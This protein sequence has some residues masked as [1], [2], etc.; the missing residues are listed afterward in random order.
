MKTLFILNNP[1]KLTTCLEAMAKDD[2]LLLIEDAV[3]LTRKNIE[4]KEISLQALN[5]DVTARGVNH[6]DPSWQLINYAK[7]VELT[8]TFDKSV[9]WL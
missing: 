9:T 6:T 2:G 1:S 7:F 8:L 5:E 3:I 4:R